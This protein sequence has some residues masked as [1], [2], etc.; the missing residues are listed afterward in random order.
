MSA[1]NPNYEES[2]NQN[3]LRSDLLE[4]NELD[5]CSIQFNRMQRDCFRYSPTSGMQSSNLFDTHVNAG[6][7]FKKY[8]CKTRVFAI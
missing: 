6:M 4:D 2:L 3:K 5:L 1:E 7:L 8:N